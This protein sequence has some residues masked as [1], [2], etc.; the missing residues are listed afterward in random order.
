MFGKA[1]N[2]GTKGAPCMGCEERDAECHAKCEKYLEYRKKC[3]ASYEDKKKY[4]DRVVASEGYKKVMR[5]KI[6]AGKA[7]RR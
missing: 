1:L 4:Y 7:N 2:I 3:Q 6:L 5:K